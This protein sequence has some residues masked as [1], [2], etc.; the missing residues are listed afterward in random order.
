MGKRVA[1]R[2]GRVLGAIV[3][4]ALVGGCH[5]QIF[6]GADHVTQPGG[7]R[8]GWHL[9][10]GAGA[11][12]EPRRKAALM[13][14]RT[15]R[16]THTK[17]EVDSMRAGGWEL[18]GDLDLPWP[19]WRLTAIGRTATA[20]IV[21]ERTPGA[22]VKAGEGGRTYG[23][24]GG[25]TRYWPGNT[26]TWYVTVGPTLETWA[27]PGATDYQAVGGEVRLAWSFDRI[28]T[29]LDLCDGACMRDL[30]AH[31]PVGASD[32]DHSIF[33]PIYAVKAPPPPSRDCTRD[34]WGGV[35]CR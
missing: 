6:A 15:R 8:N 18:R 27:L 11:A 4:I 19:A 24:A 17:G 3:A 5:L 14:T 22:G 20:D 34:R 12:L 13:V 21:Y 1:L 35:T 28:T 23:L 2:P 25:L 16:V 29:L 9:G 33:S 10:F 32:G 7:A 26:S 30:A 31:Q